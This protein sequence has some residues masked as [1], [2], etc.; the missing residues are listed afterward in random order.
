MAGT[1]PSNYIE[2]R[3]KDNVFLFSDTTRLMH[4]VE[5]GEVSVVSYEGEIYG[6]EL[7][8]GVE[9]ISYS[10]RNGTL[11]IS[12]VT[13]W[14][15]KRYQYVTADSESP[16]KY[17]KWSRK[18]FPPM[19]HGAGIELRD[20]DGNVVFNNQGYLGSFKKSFY[21]TVQ[22]KQNM[23]AIKD[24]PQEDGLYVTDGFPALYMCLCA[25]MWGVYRVHHEEEGKG[26]FLGLFHDSWDV[27]DGYIFAP[28][29]KLPSGPS[30]ETIIP[31]EKDSVCR[32]GV[33]DCFVG[34][35]FNDY[36]KCR[37]SLSNVWEQT[38]EPSDSIMAPQT[39]WLP[40]MTTIKAVKDVVF[41]YGYEFKNVENGIRVKMKKNVDRLFLKTLK[42]K[43]SLEN[44]NHI[45]HE[46]STVGIKIDKRTGDLADSSTTTVT[47]YY[48]DKGVELFP[49][50]KDG[51]AIL[52]GIFTYSG[53]LENVP[54]HVEHSDNG[55]S[56]VYDVEIKI[57]TSEGKVVEYYEA[58]GSPLSSIDTTYCNPDG[59]GDFPLL[60]YE[61]CR[62]YP[63]K[64]A[65]KDYRSFQ[66]RYDK[67][68]KKIVTDY[69][70]NSSSNYV[71]TEGISCDFSIAHIVST[72]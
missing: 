21:S 18:Y 23:L 70:A 19:E 16:I 66:Y 52:A 30:Y 57:K 68:V 51:I 33:E 69:G 63:K 28:L 31:A 14:N 46:D 15:G 48:D 4:I 40:A 9:S 10:I 20:A 61:D 34:S 1:T 43:G 56:L 50:K 60:V 8:D 65:T 22:T 13:K 27:T 72:I 2:V 59:T 12:P 54:Y 3:N 32:W 6:F 49:V 41:T 5:K 67:P 64:I 71:L 62:E 42:G 58:N 7:E 45:V 17:F 53:T 35:P 39:I 24:A 26:G 55:Y 47:R 44:L 25:K 29:G 36:K 38:I 11:Y 37:V